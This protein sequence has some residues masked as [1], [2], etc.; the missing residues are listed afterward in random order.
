[1]LLVEIKN[2]PDVLKNNLTISTKILNS[3]TLQSHISKK[4][5]PERLLHKY[6][7]RKTERH[8][9]CSILAKVKTGKIHFSQITIK[10]E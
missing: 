4:S 6:K 10:G 8:S 7:P 2:H 1:M 5:L 9:H 3:Y